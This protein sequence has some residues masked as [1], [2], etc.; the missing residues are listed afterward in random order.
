MKRIILDFVQDIGYNF[1]VFWL[2]P[3]FKLRDSALGAQE[4]ENEMT[5]VDHLED[6]R[7]TIIK[8]AVTLLV[9]MMLCFGFA[10]QF[11]AILRGPVDQVWERYEAE[12]LPEGV[13]TDDW[14]EAKS[15]AGVTQTLATLDRKH[16]EA[17]YSAEVLN[18]AKLVPF[19]H[20]SSILPEEKQISFIDESSLNAESKELCR[21]LIDSGAMLRDGNGREALKLMGAFQPGEAFMLTLSLS[22]FGGVIISCPLLI[23]FLLSFIA[24]GLHNNE[25]KLLY[26][27]VF[28]GFGLFLAGCSFAYFA[29]LPRVL[30]FFYSY[31]LELGIENDWRIG[32][33]I[34]FAAKL[35]FVFGVVFEIP[36]IVMPFIKLGLLN[37]DLMK[38]TRAYALI[39]CLF[40]AILLAPAPDPG[41]ML[42]M[43]APMY[44]LYEAC[45]IYAYFDQRRRRRNSNKDD[46]SSSASDEDAK[47]EEEEESSYSDD[48]SDASPIKEDVA[49]DDSAFAA[50]D[51]KE[52]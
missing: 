52:R 7:M 41:T 40:I 5:F 35:V 49:K 8:M 11:M 22:F 27:C 23:Y 21:A 25:R 30:S 47:E 34:S 29:V 48:L 46:E 12:H 10:P 39:A 32:Y 20:A 1:A 38:K 13:T 2:K 15:L 37:Y 33:Y 17:Q 16:L 18:L 14:I 6:L 45:I 4:E 42:I 24:P 50:V 19:I 44:L 43:A 3:L 9:S 36:V 28:F 51:G 26:K 31:S